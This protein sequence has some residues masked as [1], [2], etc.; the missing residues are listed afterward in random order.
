MKKVSVLVLIISISLAAAGCDDSIDLKE[1]IETDVK[2]HNNDK[3]SLILDSTTG[4]A[5]NPDS[6]VDLIDEIPVAI[7]ATASSGYAFK[8]WVFTEGEGYAVL[9][10]AATSSSN[11]V[12]ASGSDVSMQA[13]FVRQPVIISTFPENSNVARNMPVRIVF[14]KIVDATSV[15]DD[16]IQVFDVQQDKQ[17]TGTME[18]TGSE[19][20]FYAKDP[21]FDQTNEG[22]Y[23]WESNRSYQVFI[24][25]NVLDTDGIALLEEESWAFSVGTEIDNT[26]PVISSFTIESLKG[27]TAYTDSI[28]IL[29][30]FEAEDESLI[31]IRAVKFWNLGQSEPA[32]VSLLSEVADTDGKIEHELLVD[33]GVKQVNLKVYDMANNYDEESAVITLDTKKPEFTS[34]GLIDPDEDPYDSD[35]YAKTRELSFQLAGTDTY[36]V[37]SD[38][39]YVIDDADGS[40]S[41]QDY[42][43]T[44]VPITLPNSD[45]LHTVYFALRD[46]AGNIS[47]IV[48]DS[49]FLDRNAP[50]GT[51]QI[52]GG[53]EWANA[54]DQN[55]AIT[56]TR[57]DLSVGYGDEINIAFRIEGDGWSLPAAA[58]TYSS[59]RVFASQITDVDLFST[60]YITTPDEVITVYVKLIDQCGHSRT[61]SDTIRL[62]TDV[63]TKPGLPDL[64][65]DDDTGRSTMSGY[66]E[67]NITS[68]TD[69]LTFSGS[70]NNSDTPLLQIIDDDTGTTYGSLVPTTDTYSFDGNGFPEGSMDVVI[71]ASD[72]A[73]NIADSDHLTVI[74]DNTPPSAGINLYSLDNNTSSYIMKD[75]SPSVRL[76]ITKSD[77]GSG[78]EAYRWD[79]NRPGVEWSGWIEN[80]ATAVN[81]DTTFNEK[82]G[83]KTG[84]IEVVDR[85][86]NTN[87]AYDSIRNYYHA[88][89]ELTS[90]SLTDD[91][92]S[93]IEGSA[94]E[95]YWDYSLG[96]RATSG[97]VVENVNYIFNRGADYAVKAEAPTTINVSGLDLLGGELR[98]LHWYQSEPPYS[99]RIGGYLVD[100]DAGSDNW[101]SASSYE[102]QTGSAFDNKTHSISVSGSPTGAVRFYGRDNKD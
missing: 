35:G 99:L 52:K 66:N 14:S 4:G 81:R 95:I 5:V 58:G 20:M 6:A 47:S 18:V 71:R 86:G 92:D 101:S 57:S 40:M 31:P 29:L 50:T 75:G 34:F 46:P 100:S 25:Q 22:L 12:T 93:G 87:N 21:S 63:P 48:Q 23:L 70:C 32:T 16:T 8:N 28:N 56:L 61:V 79:T 13:V 90:I 83:D 17:I 59:E 26:P 69:N 89:F 36:I 24:R 41:W 60:G 45:G 30:S 43:T 91:G 2:S 1:L 84:Y 19:V 62:D 49:I 68:R 51:V 82:W 80:T 53:T 42:K 39:G 33:D 97:G 10:S 37:E 67:D 77:S 55:A 72:P 73:G 3:H 88:Y 74:I 102:V 15:T 7:T 64:A 9:G 98:T 76:Q 78:L 54:G 85:A 38:I 96:Y 11:V 44:A 27:S 94:G 65:N